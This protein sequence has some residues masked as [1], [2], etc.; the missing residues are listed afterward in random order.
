[1]TI[2]IAT[3][4]S[5]FLLT[6]ILHARYGRAVNSHR[7]GFAL[8]VGAI[9]PVFLIREAIILSYRMARLGKETA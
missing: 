1:M 7:L 3:Y 2:L 8:M 4:L 6:Y 5:I 9:W